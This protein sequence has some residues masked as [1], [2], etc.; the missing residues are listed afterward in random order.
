MPRNYKKEYENYHS[1][2]AAKKQRA[3]NNAARRKLMAS[4]R[5][6]K[7]DGKDVAHRDNNTRNNSA[8]N[9]S[10]QPK[11]KNRSF[12]RTKTARRAK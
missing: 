11:S 1:K 8:K 5:V 9:L 7:G 12:K 10:P 4:G 3:R 6:S 2:P